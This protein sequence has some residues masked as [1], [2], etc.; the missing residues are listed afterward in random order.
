MR[1]SIQSHLIPARSPVASSV[2][3]LSV[4]PPALMEQVKKEVEAGAEET[5]KAGKY[6]IQIMFKSDRSDRAPIAFSLSFWESGKRLHGG[7]DEMMF[8]CRRHQDAPR[9]GPGDIVRPSQL[10]SP[11]G[12]GNLIP[13]DMISGNVA[14]CPH[15]NSRHLT[16]QIGDSVFYRAGAE[17]AAAIIANWWRR[18]ECS[19]DLFAKYLPADP[20][21]AYMRSTEGVLKARRL[22]GLTIYPLARIIKDTSSGAT[23]ESRFKA[24]ILA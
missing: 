23:V 21:T 12:C 18:L 1:S 16:S 15:C 11:N 5:K 13:G 17:E 10:A 7:G 8:V 24:F 20:R 9:V 19:A 14:I 4:L 3:P 2:D 22:R 6:K